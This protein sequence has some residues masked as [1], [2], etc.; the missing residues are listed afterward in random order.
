MLSPNVRARLPDPPPVEPEPKILQLQISGT[1]GL[2]IRLTCDI[3]G[4]SGERK[5]ERKIRVKTRSRLNFESS[6]ISCRLKKLDAF[7]R[8]KAAILRDGRKL[9]EAETAAAYNYIDVR[10]SGPWGKARAVR[11]NVAIVRSGRSKPKGMI[12]LLPQRRREGLKTF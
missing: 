1:P 7:G 2:D 4:E 3:V 11:G 8:L 12:P 6:A 10:S 9:A 5:V